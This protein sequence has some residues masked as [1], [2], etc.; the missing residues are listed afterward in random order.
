MN[1]K[2][3]LTATTLILLAIV[4]GAFGAHALRGAVSDY[5]L[6]V[7][8]K[9]VFYHFLGA[10]SLFLVTCLEI[11]LNQQSIISKVA[12]GAFSIGTLIFSGSLCLFC[13]LPSSLP[14]C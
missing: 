1:K 5:H 11:L 3:V 9:S 7:W 8:D 2:M 4:L 6:N 12:R 13:W 14:R 10:I